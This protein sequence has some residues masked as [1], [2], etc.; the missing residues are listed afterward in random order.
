LKQVPE[1][2]TQVRWG[3]LIPEWCLA[4]GQSLE[5]RD[6]VAGRD[7]AQVDLRVAETE[8]EK[9]IGK[10]PTVT[11]RSLAQSSLSTEIIL[12]VTPQLAAGEFSHSWHRRLHDASLHEI[13]NEAS[14]DEHGVLASITMPVRAQYQFGRDLRRQLV[15]RQTVP[16]HELTEPA[17]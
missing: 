12:V 2:V 5:K 1:E 10:T 8:V 15:E 13:A 16:D 4:A 11:N 17:D 9:P 14:D 6:D 7:C 3:R